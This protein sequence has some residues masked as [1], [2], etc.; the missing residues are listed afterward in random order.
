MASK[1]TRKSSHVEGQKPSNAV[2]KSAAE[3][4]ESTV[5]I[6]TNLGALYDLTVKVVQSAEVQALFD[7]IYNSLEK[8]YLSLVNATHKNLKSKNLDIQ[9]KLS[10]VQTLQNQYVNAAIILEV[11]A[12][13]ASDLEIA[14]LSVS[15]KE[16]QQ[17]SK[18]L[19]A[20]LAD[21]ALTVDSNA[22]QTKAQIAVNYI[23]LS[24]TLPV[25]TPSIARKVLKL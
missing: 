24:A 12:N 23:I 18:E 10:T 8:G 9:A 2:L 4:L 15:K 1:K 5:K 11:L 17:L 22:V 6:L 3:N 14:L 20:S 16:A 19:G 21:Y 13:N 25:D 7:I